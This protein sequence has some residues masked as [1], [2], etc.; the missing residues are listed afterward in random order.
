MIPKYTAKT[1]VYRM[2]KNHLIDEFKSLNNIDFIRKYQSF[3][4]GPV[5]WAALRLFSVEGLLLRVGTGV[6]SLGGYF[7][8][9]CLNQDILFFP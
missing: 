4:L 7:G 3:F 1:K 9:L 5:F 8:G 6:W 2:I